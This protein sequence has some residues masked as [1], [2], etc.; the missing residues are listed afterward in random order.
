M[1]KIV[2]LLFAILITFALA[3]SGS[4][5]SPSKSGSDKQ[6]DTKDIIK[7]AKSSVVAV[8]GYRDAGDG[9][10]AISL[11]SGFVIRTGGYIITNLHVIDGQSRIVVIFSDRKEYPAAIV[12]TDRNT[13]LALLMVKSAAGARPLRLGNSDTV[14]QGDRVIAA[15]NPF[16]EIVISAGII[17]ANP[18]SGQFFQ[19]DA[20]I[21]PGNSGGPFFDDRGNVIGIN[22]AMMT[23]KG[24]YSRIGFALPINVAVKMLPELISKGKVERPWLGVSI[25]DIKEDE[26]KIYGMTSQMKGVLVQEVAAGGP[27][28]QAGFKPGNIILSLD[29]INVPNSIEFVKLVGS[30]RPGEAV[31]MRVLR[32]GKVSTVT[33]KLGT[34]PETQVALNEAPEPAQS[35]PQ[36]GSGEFNDY[37]EKFFGKKPQAPAKP[38]PARPAPPVQVSTAPSPPEKPLPDIGDVPE[39]GVQQRTGDFA[40][41]IGIERYQNVPASDFSKGDAEL[42]KRYL[43]AMGF[44]ERNIQLLTDERATKSGIEKTLEAW[45]PNQARAG[46]RIFLYYSGHGAPEPAKGEAYIVPYDGDPNYL[47]TTGYAISR[48]Y[49]SLGRLRTAEVIVVLDSCFSGSGGRSVLAK[50]A[51]PLVMMKERAV[52]PRNMAVMTASSGTQI[53]SSS[54]EKGHGI[55]T[56]YFLKAVKAGRKDMAGIYEYLRP[57]VEDEAKSLNIEQSPSI[58]PAANSISGRFY[59]WR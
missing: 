37:F 53:S 33:A 28:D 44:P 48:L 46:S 1:K 13:D 36:P 21:N 45:L 35:E 12:G 8:K 58:A 54:P 31:T 9:K 39:F 29:Y 3:G 50:G 38:A 5:F 59:L 2:V 30:K 16:G 57:L 20:A 56:Y 18:Q 17:S 6:V 34:R 43:R 42:V 27:A 41:V 11:G 49:D 55:F 7:A 10:N 52:S 32:D 24:D 40:V 22:T 4:A 23:K 25:K 19:T 47:T 26:A 51:R 14:Q 15:G